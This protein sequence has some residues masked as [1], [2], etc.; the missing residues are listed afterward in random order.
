V[1]ICALL[2]WRRPVAVLPAGLA[3]VLLAAAVLIRPVALLLVVPAALTVLL[4]AERRSRPL[5]AVALVAL[6]GLALGGYTVW[7]HA[8]H[9]TYALSTT[10]GVLLYARVG[11]FADCTRFAVPAEERALCDTRS[12]GGRPSADRLAWSDRSPLKRLARRSR[13]RLAGSFARRVIRHQPADYGKAVVLD[14]LRCFTPTRSQTPRY[15]ASFS[16]YWSFQ[17]GWPVFRRRLLGVARRY[18]DTPRSNRTLVSILRTYQRVAFTPGPLLAAALLLGAAAALGLGRARRSPLRAATF[19]LT[20]WAVTLAVVPALV[21]SFSP[22][23]QL[24]QL[25]LLPP[26][27]ALAVSALTDPCIE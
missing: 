20:G 25:V 24:P 10:G 26:A 17:P 11:A 2:L 8:A 1:V 5:A 4:L 14:V 16:A 13:G 15:P 12:L 7:F 27:L 3:G 23:F 6:F 22:R 18:G 21:L 9:G 19:L